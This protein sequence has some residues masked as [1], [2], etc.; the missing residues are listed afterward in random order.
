MRSAVHV[1]NFS[2]LL[3]DWH[4]EAH[5]GKTQAQL[6]ENFMSKPFNRRERLVAKRKPG[7]GRDAPLKRAERTNRLTSSGGPADST[8][9]G[10]NAGD[11]D[12]DDP[13]R[14][15]IRLQKNRRVITEHMLDCRWRSLRY[16]FFEG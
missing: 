5:K 7:R 8:A 14:K 11:N 4:T 2:K 12:T 1:L 6:S 15:R 3:L 9:E 13:Q 16:G 10:P